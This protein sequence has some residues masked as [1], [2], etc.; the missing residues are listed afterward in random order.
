MQKK[1]KLTQTHI[2]VIV[3]LFLR[4]LCYIVDLNKVAA[5]VKNKLVLLHP[6]E[7]LWIIRRDLTGSLS[8]STS[9]FGDQSS[10]VTSSCISTVSSNF[11]KVEASLRR[12]KATGIHSPYCTIKSHPPEREGDD[13]KRLLFIVPAYSLSKFYVGSKRPWWGCHT[14]ACVDSTSWIKKKIGQHSS[15]WYTY[16]RIWFLRVLWTPQSTYC[17][18]STH[19]SFSKHFKTC[20]KENTKYL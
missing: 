5:S 16:I 14:S 20:S 19:S 12:W 17:D 7:R 18:K 8:Q 13:V 9:S 15:Q 3:I 1:K 10:T 4:K 2:S 11:R 6:A